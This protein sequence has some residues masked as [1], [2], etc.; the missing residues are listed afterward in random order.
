MGRRESSSVLIFSEDIDTSEVIGRFNIDSDIIANDI[1]DNFCQLHDG[2][3][4]VT[5][6]EYLAVDRK[7]V[8]LQKE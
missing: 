8:F 6:V 1:P 7:I 4:P 5:S 2:M 3:I